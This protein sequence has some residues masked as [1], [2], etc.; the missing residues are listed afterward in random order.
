MALPPWVAGA[1]QKRTAVRI[2]FLVVVSFITFGYVLLPVRG[3]GISMEP[4]MGEGDLVFINKLTYRFREPRRGEIIAVRIADHS[5]VLVKRI[6]ALP[7]EHVGFRDGVLRINGEPLEEPY[8]T[9]RSDWDLNDA[10]LA[11]REY[12]VVGDNR[13]MPM[14]LHDMG[15]AG[16]ER[17]IGPKLF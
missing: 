17:L 3:V 13:A 7:G 1:D 15:V 5:V 12:F 2:L 4:T 6:V 14:R 10:P 9:H 16:R 8:V 11:E